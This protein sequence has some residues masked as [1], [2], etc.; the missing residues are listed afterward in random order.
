MSVVYLAEHLALGRKVALKLLAPALSEDASFRARFER[1]SQRAA[2]I[3]HPNIIPI[4][5]AGEADGE[6]YIAMR[7][8]RGSDLRLLLER[9]GPLSVSRALFLLEQ[10]A[11]ALDAAHDRGLVHRDVKPANILVEE[12]AERV[13][14]TDFGVVKHTL[15]RGATKTGFFVGT[16]DYAAPEQIEGKPI[17]AKTDVYALGCVLYECLAGEPPFARETELAVMHAHLSMPPPLLS[18]T[19]PEFPKTLDRVIARALAKDKDERYGTCTEYIRAARA[20]VLD[21]P[22]LFSRDE[23]GTA[24]GV[25]VTLASAGPMAQSAAP[26]PAPPSLVTA[27]APSSPPPPAQDTTPP[28]GPPAP[29]GGPTPPGGSRSRSWLWGGGA[30]VAAAIAAGLIVFFVTRSDDGPNEAVTTQ[31]ATTEVATTAETADTAATTETA[32]TTATTAAETGPG[33]ELAGLVPAE[34]FQNCGIASSP[35]R[36]ASATAVCVPSNGSADGFFPDQ[37]ELSTYPDS[38]SLV[39]ALADIEEEQGIEPDT[40]ACNGVQWG[41]E[42][43][44]NHGPDKP[45]GQRLCYFDG[46]NAV[47]V[48][49]HEKLGQA[50]H[51]DVLG[52]AREGGTDHARLFSWWRFWTHRIGKLDA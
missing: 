15:S 1:E 4:Y 20:A 14:V 40:G 35:R 49:T 18:D 51:R 32:D 36:G 45:G 3:D 16:T 30:A 5:D 8:V 42:V 23:P 34:I 6:L 31:A 41:G 44:W 19:R 37:L 25:A 26:E 24:G 2:E 28:G 7:Y 38:E 29:P 27:A 47:L 48:W 17:D 33:A 22:V 52:I 12:P 9:D 21:Q 11:S 46:D 50:D 43:S 13:Y 39:A 10:A